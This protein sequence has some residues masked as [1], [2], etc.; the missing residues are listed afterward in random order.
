MTSES[1]RIERFYPAGH[2]DRHTPHVC[3]RCGHPL[4]SDSVCTHCADAA[5]VTPALA[6]ERRISRF[7]DERARLERMEEVAL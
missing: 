7:P 4:T 5:E 6:T 1:T 2:R 3:T